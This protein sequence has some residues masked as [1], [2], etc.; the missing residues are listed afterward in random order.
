MTLLKTARNT[1]NYLICSVTES[2]AHNLRKICNLSAQFNYKTLLLIAG[3]T[4]AFKP[5]L[6]IS[7]KPLTGCIAGSGKSFIHVRQ[8]IAKVIL[9]QALPVLLLGFEVMIERT[10]WHTCG[11]QNLVKPNTREPLNHHHSVTR[12]EQM[13]ARIIVTWFHQCKLP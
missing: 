9:E 2:E 3:L 11:L 1:F 4:I 8:I 12:I 5:F 10:F 7:H 13:L 6:P